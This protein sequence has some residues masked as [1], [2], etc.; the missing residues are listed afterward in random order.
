VPPALDSSDIGAAACRAAE[1]TF[2]A[3]LVAEVGNFCLAAFL[4]VDQGMAAVVAF[5]EASYPVDFDIV[6]HQALVELVRVGTVAADS[7]F[8]DSAFVQALA[9]SEACQEVELEVVFAVANL[10]LVA[11]AACQQEVVVAAERLNDFEEET[12]LLAACSF[13]ELVVVA[14]AFQEEVA[15]RLKDFAEIE[16]QALAAS[17]SFEEEA[18][19]V[20]VV[21]HL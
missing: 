15:E 8:E 18:A 16:Q 14:A 2:Q 12:E 17:P 6:E 1:E 19:V 13:E 7:S 21:D 4:V 9:A 10:E 11:A 3:A 5:L 20:V